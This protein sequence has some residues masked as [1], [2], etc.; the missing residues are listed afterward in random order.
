MAK[1]LYLLTFTQFLSS[2][3]TA[4]WGFFLVNSG[5]R[6][7]QVYHVAKDQIVGGMT[8]YSSFETTPTQSKGI[9]Q[10]NLIADVAFDEQYMDAICQAVSKERKFDL[11]VNNCQRWCAQIL[12]ELVRHGQLTQA[13]VDA[14]KARGFEP[15]V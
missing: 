3:K 12:A 13:Q 15:L 14:L 6:R 8:N 11:I 5:A 4:H 7:G 9:R 2:D 10:A 1:Q